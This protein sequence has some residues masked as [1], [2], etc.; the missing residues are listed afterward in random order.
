MTTDL[1]TTEAAA[2]RL[3]I[4]RATLYDWL[5]Q[6][7]RGEFLIR[8]KPVTIGYYQSGR[9]GQG[10]IQIESQEIERL[11]GFMRVSPKQ[12]NERKLPSKN[13]TY[14][15]ISAKLGRPEE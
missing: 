1:L 11:L 7:D 3:G 14:R 10:R 15:H 13:Q 8:G 4:T 12:Q 5:A 6:S 2:Q 9:K